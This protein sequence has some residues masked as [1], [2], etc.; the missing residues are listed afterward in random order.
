MLSSLAACDSLYLYGGMA[1]WKSTKLEKNHW[2]KQVRTGCFWDF[3]KFVISELS[4]APRKTVCLT[5][6]LLPHAAHSCE[7]LNFFG[8]TM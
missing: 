5:G 6:E 2:N 1:S 4:V 3:S 8:V 7:R